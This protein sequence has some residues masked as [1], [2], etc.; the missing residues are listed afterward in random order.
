MNLHLNPHGNGTHTECV[1]HISKEGHTLNNC[2]QRFVFWADLVQVETQRRDAPA[3]FSGVDD[4]ITLEAVQQACAGLRGAGPA[5]PAGQAGQAAAAE[6]AAGSEPAGGAG[7]G[8]A[9]APGSGLAP[10]T[11]LVI[12]SGPESERRNRNWSGANAP[13]L[14]S[15]ALSWLADQGYEHLL[16][17]LPSVDRE[18]DGGA[19]AGHR[20]WWRYPHATRLQATITELIV[21]PDQ[22]APGRYLLHLQVPHMQ[23]DA[24]PSQPVL[25]AVKGV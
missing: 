3:G 22:L 16:L 25:Y 13:Y 15:E 11:A 10:A 14:S 19:L 20:A 12:R 23:S 7:F 21:V 4:V 6:P 17:D 8:S 1:G 5:G 9:F 18:E 2:L 24:A